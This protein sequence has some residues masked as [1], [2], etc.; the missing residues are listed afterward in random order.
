MGDDLCRRESPQLCT[1][2]IYTHSEL[3]TGNALLYENT[4]IFS[5]SELDGSIQILHPLNLCNSETAPPLIGFDKKGQSQFVHYLLR[6]VAVTLPQEVILRQE[7][8]CLF[9]I[10]L[11]CK[12][13]KCEC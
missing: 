12:L 1:L 13:V 7:D 6:R 9:Q 4:V 10:G 11:A 3:P 8:T 5:E 2:H